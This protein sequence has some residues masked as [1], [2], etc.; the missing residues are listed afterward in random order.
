[1]QATLQTMQMLRG[2]LL[3]LLLLVTAG[4][5]ARF[6][7][8][9]EVAWGF[10]LMALIPLFQGLMHFDVARA[11]RDM[12]FRPLIKVILGAECATLL[13]I[14]PLFLVF[15][16]YRTALFALLLQQVLMLAISHVLA[17]R[18]YRLAF[19]RAMLMRAFVFGWPLMLDAILMFGIFQ[20]D[21]LI[22]ANRLGVTDLGLY[23]LAFMLTFIATTVLAKTLNPTSS[24]Q[25]LL[26]TGRS[27]GFQAVLLD[28]GAGGSASLAWPWPRASPSSARTSSASSSE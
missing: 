10:Q 20:G 3:A 9:P 25:A 7:S 2:V 18:R 27:G 12:D 11:Q 15:G 14:Y 23:S 13:L 5:L 16:D 17:E 4:P 24:S 1:M 8:V 19:D 28:R 22:V 6:M 26:A 21:R